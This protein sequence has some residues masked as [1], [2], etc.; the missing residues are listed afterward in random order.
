MTQAFI[1]YPTSNNVK[2]FVC[3]SDTEKSIV[4]NI[5]FKNKKAVARAVWKNEE[6]KE[7]I[8]LEFLS[9]VKSEVKH[10]AKDPECLLKVT[11]PAVVTSFNNEAFYAQLIVANLVKPGKAKVYSREELCGL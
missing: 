6:M 5:V 8:I 3:E 9:A 11:N 4:K 1:G 2:E 7:Q 10:Y